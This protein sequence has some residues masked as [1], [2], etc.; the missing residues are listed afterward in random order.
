MKGVAG[1]PLRFGV[2]RWI[3]RYFCDKSETAQT[4]S[5]NLLNLVDVL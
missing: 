2:S 4:Q 3:S 1:N 5:S